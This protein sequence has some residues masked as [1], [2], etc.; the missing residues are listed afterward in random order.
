MNHPNHNWRVVGAA[1]SGSAHQRLG[2]PCQDAFAYRL[3]EAGQ[4]DAGQPGG[5]LLAAMADGA[6]SAGRSDLGA[7][8]AVTA[9]LECLTQAG[10][11]QPSQELPDWQ[12]HLYCAFEAARQAVLDQAETDQ[13][14][15]REYAA[16]LTCLVAAANWVAIGTLGD[17]F[18]IAGDAQGDLYTANFL[19]RGEYA[20]E[21]NFIS[22][23][24][25]LFQVQLTVIEQPV[26]RLAMLSDGLS[27]LALNLPSQEPYRPFFQPLFNFTATL[28]AQDDEA[29]AQAIEKLAGFLASERVC[30]RT[31]DDKSLLL[32]VREAPAA[33]AL[34]PILIQTSALKKAAVAV[35]PV[36]VEPDNGAQPLAPAMYAQ[37]AP[38]EVPAGQPMPSGAEASALVEPQDM[39]LPARDLQE[40]DGPDTGAPESGA[41]EIGA[42]DTDLAV[43]GGEE[44]R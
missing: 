43:S 1:V 34:A 32:A 18:V 5:F 10:E 36:P 8:L 15:V 4:T 2:L 7:R 39:G 38:C 3:L 44:T 41:P 21:T 17:C 33:L 35:Y 31:D 6:G 23:D 25:A 14:P 37:A 30:A 22:Q 26:T 9:A 28:E 13:A 24:D 40:M 27:R 11:T 29:H 20:N 19:Q 16:T 12:D 42:L